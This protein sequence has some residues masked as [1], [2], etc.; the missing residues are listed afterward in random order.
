MNMKLHLTYGPTRRIRTK[1]VA[2]VCAFIFLTM[3]LAQLYKYED[4]ASVLSIVLPVNN[5]QLSVILAGAIAFA[6]LL[7]FPYLLGMYVSKL[8]R[9]LSGLFATLAAVF[10]LLTTLTNAHASNSAILSTALSLPGGI[11][12][13]LWAVL[14]ATT[15]TYVIVQDSRF[16]HDSSS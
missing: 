9:A 6:E 11:V 10:W 7:A 12:S 14:L 16:R 2:R 1:I 3:L 13:L 4:F 8:M 15:L 5:Q